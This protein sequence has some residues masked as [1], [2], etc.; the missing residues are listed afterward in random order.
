MQGCIKRVGGD[1]GITVK[2]T[3]NGCFSTALPEMF[4]VMG[5]MDTVNLFRGGRFRN[6]G[7]NPGRDTGN[8]LE[9]AGV[10]LQMVRV[11]V[12][13]AGRIDYNRA[14]SHFRFHLVL[15]GYMMLEVP[16]YSYYANPA[17]RFFAAA[18]KQENRDGLIPLL[19]K[20]GVL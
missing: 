13:G 18:G 6:A 4:R 20:T 7:G 1:I 19:A 10:A 16:G 3:Q 12:T 15:A 14:A 9:K 5:S 11:V 17:D 8:C 2:L